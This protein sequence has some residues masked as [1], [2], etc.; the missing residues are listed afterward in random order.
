VN[1]T[2]NYPEEN[3]N[4]PPL[5]AAGA[6]Q[7]LETPPLP[8]PVSVQTGVGANQAPQ[9]ESTVSPSLSPV[10]VLQIWGRT[11]LADVRSSLRQF[12]RAILSLETQR[13]NPFIRDL[14]RQLHQL[15]VRASRLPSYPRLKQFRAQ[16]L[17]ALKTSWTSFASAIPPWLARPL[18]INQQAARRPA[19]AAAASRVKRRRAILSLRRWLHEPVTTDQKRTQGNQGRSAG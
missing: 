15:S 4:L 17:S 5:A 7:I 16:A 1:A 11:L 8:Q 2:E 18:G 13:W 9:A 12:R 6:S 14:R 19:Q 3:F 10:D